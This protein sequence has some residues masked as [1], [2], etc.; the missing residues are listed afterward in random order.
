LRKKRREILKI[1]IWTSA[2]IYRFF[3]NNWLADF[4][5][6]LIIFSGK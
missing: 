1:A 5:G 2:E 6:K 3:Q 4:R